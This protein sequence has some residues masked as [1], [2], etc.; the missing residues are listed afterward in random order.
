MHTH[1]CKHNLALPIGK[2]GD[3]PKPGNE[4]KME[5]CGTIPWAA[6]RSKAA[7]KIFTQLPQ[8]YVHTHI[9]QIHP[10]KHT[11]TYLP[12]TNTGSRIE[13][14]TCIIHFAHYN[15]KHHRGIEMRGR[16]F[17]RL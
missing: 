1:L 14:Q 5:G 3:A 11:Y 7:F 12:H 9:Q 13:I 15:G 4:K 6:F 2:C 10:Q 17:L 8:N 16:G